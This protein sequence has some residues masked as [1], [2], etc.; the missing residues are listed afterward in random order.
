[1]VSDVPVLGKVRSPTRDPDSVGGGMGVVPVV[2]KTALI[3]R[4]LASIPCLLYAAIVAY[5]MV[6]IPPGSVR[7]AV[8]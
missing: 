4:M 5:S 2:L 7:Q 8:L 6:S 1:M 3:S